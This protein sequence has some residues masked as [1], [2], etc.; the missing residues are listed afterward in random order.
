MAAEPAGAPSGSQLVLDND[1]NLNLLVDQVVGNPLHAK[2]G[3]G[4]WFAICK[5]R[6]YNSGS[7]LR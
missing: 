1:V 4:S 7:Q 3:A 6:S 5:C 2:L